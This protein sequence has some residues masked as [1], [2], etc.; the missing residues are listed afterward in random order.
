MTSPSYELLVG[1]FVRTL[2]ERH[3]IAIPAELAEP[4]LSQGDRCVIAKERDGCLSLWTSAVWEPRIASAV[5][6]IRSKLTAGLLAHRVGEVQKL[7]RLLSTRHRPVTLAARG[8]LVLPEGF[9]EF[10]G[11]QPGGD[12]VVVGA[13][14]CVELWRPDAWQAFVAAEMPQFRDSFDQLTA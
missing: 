4:L 8:R 6:V 1:E 12:L 7:G 3:R 2:D 5:E 13:A 11:V 10:L 9:R 14:V